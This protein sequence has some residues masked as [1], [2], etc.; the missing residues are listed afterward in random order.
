MAIDTLTKEAE[1]LSEE[2]LQKVIEYIQF[3]KYKMKSSERSSVGT[4]TIKRTPGG[5]TGTFVMAEDFDVTL[6]YV[7]ENSIC[8][9]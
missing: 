5:L 1:G 6:E 8:R 3:L 9:V 4:K 7:E 2:E